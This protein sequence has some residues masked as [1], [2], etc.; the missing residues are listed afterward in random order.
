MNTDQRLDQ[1]LPEP[2][3]LQDQVVHVALVEWGTGSD[4]EPAILL[5]A[6]RH[7]AAM[8]AVENVV[9]SWC[10]CCVDAPEFLAEHSVSTGWGE[11]QLLAWLA[12]LKEATTVPWVTISVEPVRCSAFPAGESQ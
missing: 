12:E 3:A 8:A 4:R 7:G 5:A 2:T 6:S 10:D 11:G 1:H 9:S